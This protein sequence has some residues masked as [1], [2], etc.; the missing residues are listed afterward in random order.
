MNYADP[1]LREIA[2]FSPLDVMLADIAVRVQLSPTDYKI[3]VEHY[4][5]IHDWIERPESP[6]FDLVEEFY[7][8]GGFAIGATVARHATDAEFDLD[9]MAQL[10]LKEDADA[11]AVLSLMHEAICGEP[12]SRYHDKADRKTRCSTVH[13]VGMH[14]DITPAI[15]VMDREA[16]TS[17]IFHSKDAERKSLLAN[18]AGFAAWFI[19]MT[20]ADEAFGIFFE[21]RSLAYDRARQTLLADSEAQPVPVRMPAYRKSRAVIALQL[22]KRWRNLAYDRRHKRLRLPPSVLLSFYVGQH[23]NRTCTLT[24]ELIHQ[25][26][27]MISVLEEAEARGQTVYAENPR[28]PEDELTDRWPCDL[29]EQRVFIDELRAFAFQVHR[30][31]KGVPL[32]EMQRVLQELFGEKAAADAVRAYADQHIR[33][34]ASG[35]SFHVTGSGTMPALG[36][37]VAGAA[38]VRPTPRN[39]FYGD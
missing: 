38:F 25:V 31:D 7:T 27:C 23:A 4:E 14:L 29:A 39:T 3:A 8:Q 36:S 26:E 21:D 28:C 32:P 10:A 30:L 9:A 2:R 12:G 13:Y 34:D 19:S 24:E 18:P 22:I 1:I 33:D 11:E 20:P 15:R 5:A 17:V 16:K 37:T 35:R 6:L